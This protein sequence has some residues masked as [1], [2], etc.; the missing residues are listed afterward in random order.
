MR[1]HRTEDGACRVVRRFAW[2]PTPTATSWVWLAWVS[3]HQEYIRGVAYE[4]WITQSI[5]AEKE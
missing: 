2:F 3:C 5:T 1:W 4:G